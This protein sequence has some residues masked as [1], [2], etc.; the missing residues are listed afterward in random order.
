[1]G[2]REVLLCLRD[3][4]QSVCRKMVLSLSLTDNGRRREACVE[5][6]EER[7]LDEKLY[8]RYLYQENL[9]AL[10]IYSVVLNVKRKNVFNYFLHIL[11]MRKD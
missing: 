3:R 9:T 1:M 5:E 11:Y 8:Y 6:N 7:P 4:V 10:K 2:A